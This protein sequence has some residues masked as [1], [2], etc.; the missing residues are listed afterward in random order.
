LGYLS[1]YDNISGNSNVSIGQSAL[2]CNIGGGDN[3][4]IGCNALI[5]NAYGCSNVAI[6]R[7]AGYYET[8]SNRLHI[9]NVACSGSTSFIYGEFDNKRLKTNATFEVVTPDASGIC[10]E[11][12]LGDKN[13]DGSWRIVVSGS[14]LVAQTRV[15]T[16]WG[17]NKVIAP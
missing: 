12:Y 5:R 10:N 9:A 14:S 11:F 13:T 2:R 16:V 3:I 4:A 8:G 7:D 17:G 6:G 15:A 1:L